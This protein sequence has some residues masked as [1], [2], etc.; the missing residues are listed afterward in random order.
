MHKDF[1]TWNELKKTL[2]QLQNEIYFQEGDI[3]WCSMWV[4]IKDESNG[5]WSYFR[6]PILILKKLSESTCIALPLTSQEKVWSW[7]TS[8]ILDNEKQTVLL[9]QI[10]MLH[11]NRFQRK[12]WYIDNVDMK[13]IK[14]K[15]S[16][17]LGL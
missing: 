5:K 8:C 4:N 9:Y 15:L 3:W 17:L 6:R 1:D 2:E 7:F 16:I 10:R 12:L 13:I 11:K 14:K